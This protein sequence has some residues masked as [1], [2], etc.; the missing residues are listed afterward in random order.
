MHKL[1]LRF[2]PLS[3]FVLGLVASL[4]AFVIWPAYDALVFWPLVIC[5]AMVATGI[6][7]LVQPNRS[8][9]RN[10]PVIGHLRFIFEAIRPEMRQYFFESDLDGAPFSRE[11]R[12]VVYQRAKNQLDK[13]PFGTL[14]DVYESG[15][16]WMLHSLWPTTVPENALRVMIG[17]PNCLQPYNASILNI[18]AMS[19][20]ALSA[21]AIRALNAGAKAGGFAHDTG[22]G[23]ISPYHL[24][25]GGD[26][27][28]EIGS[29]YFG[30]RNLDG[31]FSDEAFIRNALRPEVKMIEIKLNQG[32]K[33]GHG[34]VLP[35]AKITEEIA[36]IRGIRMGEDCVSPARHPAFSTPRELMLFIEKLRNLSKGKPIGFKLCPGR[37]EEIGELI[38][39]M[40][41]T[42]IV[43][44]FIVVD[45]KEG[46]TGAAPAEFIDNLGM[47]LREGLS[48][49]HASLAAAGLR[50]KLR[51]GAAGKIVT[52]YDMARTLALG[53]DWCNAARAFMFSLGCVQ[54]QACHTG[55]CPT[56]VATQDPTRQRAIDVANKAKRVENFHRGTVLSLADLLAASG[57]SHPSEIN[58]R[59]FFRRA[60]DGHVISFADQYQFPNVQPL[61]LLRTVN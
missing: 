22:E 10:Y 40:R 28:W 35:A 45:G 21:N 61:P 2:L 47:P 54:A 52:G 7:D 30:C 36:L 29:G 34:G 60:A 49:I 43:P 58:R 37:Y 38:L 17:G 46:G 59:G 23:S 3:L 24:E 32:A 12:A 5:A 6:Y 42:G 50:D 25:N 19:F 11:Q 4:A 9:L 48:L 41:E 39:A 56:G 44:D 33:P 57:Y 51:I 13:K 16:E 31:S 1:P 15:Y 55:R 26:L 18:S 53:A 14:S 8:I 20:G 27:I